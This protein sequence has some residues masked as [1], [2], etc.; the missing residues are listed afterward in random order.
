MQHTA[1]T[2]RKLTP[3]IALSKVTK[4]FG[5]TTVLQ[6]VNFTLLP[7]EVHALVGENG[8]G[9]S[10]CLSLL[11]GLHQPTEG[12]IEL[13]GLSVSVEDPAYAQALGISCVFQELSLA[14]SLSI[15]EN[16]FVGRT[17]TRFGLVDW[18]E[19]R[20]RAEALL[21]AFD[22]SIDVSLPVDSLPIST[23]QIVE[24]AKALS[25]NSKI[26]L[27][28][29]PTSALTPD[30]VTG[31][32]K[33]LRNLT[34][35]GIGIVYVSHHMSE[36]FDIS[37]RITVLRDGQ[38]ISTQKVEETSREQ[39]VNEMVGGGN[40]DQIKR[41]RTEKG[42][43]ILTVENLSN[44]GYFEDVSFSV[45]KGEIFGVAG[46]LGSHR[47][48]ILRAVVGLE[49][50]HS[51]SVYLRGTVCQFKSLSQAMKAGIG[52]VPEERKTEGLFLEDSVSAN[53]V[54]ASLEQHTVFSL[55]NRWSIKKACLGAIE[56]FSVKTS[57]PKQRV[58]LLSGGNQQKIMLAKWLERAP[59]ILIIEEPT[60]GN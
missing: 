43:E 4:R 46:L 12:S 35:K 7:G 21:A 25:L 28:D 56:T 18:P 24:I 11:Y 15:A 26:L 23:R 16:I 34:K 52:F 6:D 47:S 32:F 10:T 44:P 58:G 51:G 39:V 48:E 2:E 54:S 55:L 30:E 50:A 45:S 22:L 53:L 31:L 27:L 3:L 13:D 40:L 9:K 33:V 36:I 37:D 59:D 41:A 19:L 17:P 1:Q 8:A 60:K 42:E 20:Q 14:G 29:E 49:K 57:G 38:H 5:S